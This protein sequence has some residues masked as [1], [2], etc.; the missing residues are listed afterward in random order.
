M[1]KKRIIPILL[2]ENEDMVKSIKYKNLSYVGDPINIIKIF[3]EK[4]ADEIIILDIKKSFFNED[5]NYNFIRNLATECY[6]PLTY[7]GG[8]KNL[9]QAE[10]LFSIGIEKLVLNSINYK[11]LKLI[12]K[13]T[14]RFGSQSVIAAIDLDKNIFNNLYLYDWLKRKKIEL[15]IKN[16]IQNCIEYGAGEILINFVFNEGTQCGFDTNLI[17]FIDFKMPVPLII[18]GGINSEKNIKDCLKCEKIDAIAV[19]S[20]FI[21][22]G[23][24]KAVL[25]SYF[26]D[27]EKFNEQ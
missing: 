9:D 26:N 17:N 16:H 5:P 3:N 25:I 12:K 13:I 27:M 10:K 23:P 24:H 20:Y 11:N 21:Y 19:G 1:L 15:N 7:G 8:I 22:H 6:M 4:E 14:E 2:I 18:N